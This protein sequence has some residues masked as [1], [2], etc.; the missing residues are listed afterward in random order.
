M[1]VSDTATMAM[2]QLLTQHKYSRSIHRKICQRFMRSRLWF[3]HKYEVRI[4][5]WH[6]G[7][8]GGERGPRTAATA[9]LRFV[10]KMTICSCDYQIWQTAFGYAII[11]YAR[12][13]RALRRYS[14]TNVYS[15]RHWSN[16]KCRAW[17]KGM[18][19]MGRRRYPQ[20][21]SSIWSSFPVKSVFIANTRMS[22]C[23]G[24]FWLEL[25]LSF[26]PTALYFLNDTNMGSAK[27]IVCL[28]F[29]LFRA[30]PESA[31][32]QLFFFLRCTNIPNR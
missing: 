12:F 16:A 4:V 20:T 22:L 28:P 14:R 27:P 23:N 21:S 15:A 8:G 25:L 32:M 5:V 9:S 18:V 24:Q 2:H 29:W 10:L 19:P 31:W 1:M 30:V 3:L 26:P 13:V 6:E 11:S 17:G 7:E